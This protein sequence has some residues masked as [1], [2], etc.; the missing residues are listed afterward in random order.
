MSEPVTDQPPSHGETAESSSVEKS[1]R[2]R[3]MDAKVYPTLE[4]FNEDWPGW[5][6]ELRRFAVGR[7]MRFGVPISLLDPDD[8]VQMTAE[9]M[10]AR[11]VHIR[12]PH[13][14][15]YAPARRFIM[16]AAQ[17][18]PDAE[19]AWLLVP[20]R[21]GPACS[22]E[23]AVL[24]RAARQ[25]LAGALARLLTAHQ[26]LVIHA[27]MQEEVPYEV[28]ADELA[29]SV[30]TVSAHRARA[31][32]KLR[33]EAEQHDVLPRDFFETMIPGLDEPDKTEIEDQRG[34]RQLDQY[35]IGG[36]RSPW[37]VFS[38]RTLSLLAGLAGT[39]TLIR[40]GIV[41]S[42]LALPLLLATASGTVWGIRLADHSR[43]REK[44]ANDAKRARLT[45]PRDAFRRPP[46]RP[47]RVSVWKAGRF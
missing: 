21:C 14:Y 28:I 22:A 5:Y 31:L 10:L 33:R 32:A 44:A 47:V 15:M 18:L 40:N 36:R 42:P 11:W 12:H 13:R 19:I 41:P 25:W 26:R 1:A 35:R 4:A 30:G 2:F 27:L 38:A 45:P 39:A 34:T 37:W 17:Q 8:V 23:R 43:R 3:A 24:T 46:G 9:A 6:H 16:R 29:I 20:P 7:L